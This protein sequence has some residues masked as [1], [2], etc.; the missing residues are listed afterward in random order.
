MINE[1]REPYD[2]CLNAK[3]GYLR[4]RKVHAG[5]DRILV[6]QGPA[7]RRRCACG[8]IPEPIRS[9]SESGSHGIAKESFPRHRENLFCLRVFRWF[10]AIS[11]LIL[12]EVSQSSLSEH[13]RRFH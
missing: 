6:S 11:L 8:L 3:A 12:R 9:F 4:Y 7:G 10:L 5:G 1:G 2:W 13:N